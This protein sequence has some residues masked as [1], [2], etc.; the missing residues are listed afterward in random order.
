MNVHFGF[1]EI[2][3]NRLPINLKRGMSTCFPIEEYGSDTTKADV[4]TNGSRVQ[5]AAGE[6]PP[7]SIQ[8]ENCNTAVYE[9][10]LTVTDI[11]N[12]KPYN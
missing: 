4:N 8:T 2:D 9:V 12:H 1:N 7:K 6:H 5:I 11:S 10:L 3:F